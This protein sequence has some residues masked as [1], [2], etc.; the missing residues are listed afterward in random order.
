MALDDPKN[1]DGTSE[2]NNH[3]EI[4]PEG[5]IGVTEEEKAWAAQKP[6]H[7]CVPR[8]VFAG[9]L[10]L[11]LFAFTAGGLWYYR[12]NILPEKYYLQATAQFEA[13][14]YEKS[15]ALYEKVA[16]IEPNR[17]DIYNRMARALAKV[18]KK[19]EALAYY[20]KHLQKQPDDTGAMWEAG[21]LCAEKKDYGKALELMTAMKNPDCRR[22]E[23]LAEINLAAG[24]REEAADSLLEAALSC[25][26]R[27]KTLAA[28]KKLMDMGYYGHALEAYKSA[29]ELD[30]GD[31]R[32]FHGANAA[33]AMLGLPT[34][35]AMVITPGKSL[36]LVKLGAGKDEVKSVM[37]A[38]ERKSFTKIKRSKTEIWHYGAKN[39]KHSMAIFLA[40]GKVKEIETRYKEFKTEEGL[41]A[42]NFLLEK[43]SGAIE[44]RVKL[45]DGSVR[46]DVK[47][48]G[49]TFYAAGM[50]EAGNGAKYAKLIIHKKGEKPLG[51]SKFPWANISW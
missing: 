6:Q 44:G 8:Y 48:G 14:S 4:A 32:A 30:D 11:I 26:D 9:A 43:Y 28:A 2:G 5:K 29:M 10:V 23:R 40:G 24:L 15:F 37:G 17:R 12:K 47:G 21:E 50:N 51:E 45:S 16:K 19:D 46:V 20:E 31:N 18:G 25:Q 36:G 35:P 27:E 42:G 39:K 38:P 7:P 3:P 22:L 1:K 34:D 13:G 41:G 49:M 33:K